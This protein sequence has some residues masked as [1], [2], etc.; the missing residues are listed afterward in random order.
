MY[1]DTSHDM[2]YT[3]ENYVLRSIQILYE[4]Q[5][6]IAICTTSTYAIKNDIVSEGSW[7]NRPFTHYSY[8]YSEIQL[9][10]V[11]YYSYTQEN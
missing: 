11:N 1:V 3:M 10:S 8:T 4:L 9:Y 6:Y 7:L 2:N 5:S